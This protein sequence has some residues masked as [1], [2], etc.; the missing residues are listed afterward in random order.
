M[1]NWRRLIVGDAFRLP[2]RDF[3]YY[4][5]RLLLCPFLFFTIAGFA[6]LFGSG[7]DHRIGF[8]YAALSILTILLARGRFI[9]IL[10][11]LAYCAVRSS[12]S[13]FLRHDQ[14]T[15]LVAIPSWVVL[16]VLARNLRNYKPSYGWPN[17][18]TIL[19]LLVGLSS[20][21]FA[22]LVFQWVR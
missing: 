10:G 2:S 5:D 8:E 12:L 19:D 16:I 6:N 14:F 17:G 21:G 1:P 9:L 7:R 11:A 18:I 3:N 15:L 20:I 13:V 4:R 22:M